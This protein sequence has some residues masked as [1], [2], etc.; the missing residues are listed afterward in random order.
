MKFCL[1][2]QNS[3]Q[4]KPKKSNFDTLNKRIR[5]YRKIHRLTGFYL[6]AF[7]LIVAITGILLGWKKNSF[8][9][10]S[11]DNHVGT[12]VSTNQWLPVFELN[13]IANQ[14]LK[15]H[16]NH[17]ISTAL[18]RIDISPDKGQI[19]FIYKNNYYA[20]QLDGANGNLLLVEYRLAD[21]LENIHDGSI[22]DKILQTNTNFFKLT[23]TSITGLA[24]VLFSFTGFWL[25][26]GPKKVKQNNSI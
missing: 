12:T 5:W 15:L 2:A 18:D 7:L 17:A 21:L 19:K 10:I 13:E 6:F 1:F 22:L 8:G 9:I 3:S 26:Y 23:F 25:Y 4:V 11:A 14:Q 20:I 24:I 16:T